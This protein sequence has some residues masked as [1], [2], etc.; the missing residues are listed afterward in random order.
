[1]TEPRII[2]RYALYDRIASGGMATV[3]YG[4]LAGPVGFSRTVAIK[5][6][7]P[8]FAEDPDFVSMFLD[9]ARLAARVHH[10]NVVPTVDVVAT[11]G[12]LF[13]VMEYVQGET[14]GRLLRIAAKANERVPPPIATAIASGLLHGLHAA[15]EAKDERGEP[16]GIVHRDV[17]PQNVLV[18]VDGMPRVLD[19]GVAK[20]AGRLQT[21][22]A[23]QIKG[24]LAYMAPEQATR[25]GVTRRSDVYSAAVVLW[26]TLAGRRLFDAD[27]EAGMLR[28]VLAGASIPPSRFANG[29]PAALDAVVLRALRLD[30]GERFATAREM[31]S[32]L[33]A[34]APVAIPPTVGAWVERIAGDAIASQVVRLAEIESQPPMTP[35]AVSSP[36]A[37]PPALQPSRPQPARAAPGAPEPDAT[38]VSQPSAVSVASMRLRSPWGK[39]VGIASAAAVL[40]AIVAITVLSLRRT[41][42]RAT[43][44]P[45]ATSGHAPVP[46]IAPPPSE[47]AEL[48]RAPVTSAAGPA[49]TSPVASGP[50]ATSP[51]ATG[52]KPRPAVT[53]RAAPPSPATTHKPAPAPSGVVFRDP[54]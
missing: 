24:K 34:A 5:R 40:V 25:G 20:A 16:L 29:V 35:P 47:S 38:I 37:N 12:E 43:S 3:H 28:A 18:G 42:E 53:V 14:L 9:E 15:H 21:T 54:G 8:H 39:R 17:S 1:V 46:T 10:P 26:E 48:P 11:E 4:R 44:A 30:P 41:G 51:V 50:A 36:A 22:R 49:A 27:D 31:A 45:S 2:G 23:G 33:E 52:P 32:A 19:F 6:M 7:H 13:L